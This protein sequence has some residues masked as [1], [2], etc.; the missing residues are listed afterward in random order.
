M[1]NVI[2]YFIKKKLKELEKVTKLNIKIQAYC[3]YLPIL[4][5]KIIQNIKTMKISKRTKKE[6]FLV[7]K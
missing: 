3:I 6:Y 4:R 7:L 2:K 1:L 5:H